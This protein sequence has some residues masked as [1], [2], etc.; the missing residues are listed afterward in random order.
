MLTRWKSKDKDKEKCEKSSNQKPSSS[1][2]SKKKRKIG[3]DGGKYLPDFTGK[4]LCWTL[5]FAT[6]VAQLELNDFAVSL[7]SLR[8]N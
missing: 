2:T 1:S 3:R 6:T 5:N 7:G 4:M 8:L